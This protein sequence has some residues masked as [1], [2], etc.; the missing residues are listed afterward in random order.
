MS[1]AADD[2]PEAAR[3]R[4]ELS[5]VLFVLAETAI[6][7]VI[8]ASEKLSG[9]EIPVIQLQFLRFLGGFLIL[10]LLVLARGRKLADYRSRLWRLQILRTL[11]G[12]GGGAAALQAPLWVPYIDATAV[13]LLDGVIAIFLGLIVLKER[14]APLHWLGSLLL[15]VGAL[16]VVLGQGAFSSGQ[17]GGA[18]Q[19]LYWVGLGVAGI[20]ALCFGT[21]AL[22]TRVLA[23][24][25]RPMVIMLHI[26]AIAVLLLAV[27]VI[28][29]WKAVPL[30]D[31]L[32]FLLLGPLGLLGQFCYIRACALAPVSL[33]GPVEYSRLI[34]AGLLGWLALQQV[35]SPLSLA[36][37]A[38]LLAGGVIL[39]RR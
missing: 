29:T 39:A 3:R 30:L 36:G 27:P 5:A 31:L 28:L 20:A 37:G 15:V 14:L 32:P 11:L 1:E 7:T 35:P 38:V 33:V 12:V 6:F 23:R 9:D 16:V 25:D 18:A 8:F 19:Q 21:E 13:E 4:D 10:F 26:N 17:A 34:F 24:Q 2:H 22:L